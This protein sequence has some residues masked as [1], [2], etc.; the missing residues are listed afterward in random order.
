MSVFKLIH[1]KLFVSQGGIKLPLARFLKDE[2][3]KLNAASENKEEV[4]EVM[5]NEALSRGYVSESFLEKIKKREETFP[6]GLSL[7]HYGIAIPHTDAECIF[8]QFIGVITLQEPIVFQSMDDAS[9]EVYVK[10]ILMLGLN[11]PHNQ[12]AV[13]Q[14]I[15]QLVQ[16][17]E[18][19]E[20]LLAA[21][22]YEEVHKIFKELETI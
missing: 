17:E 19:Y 7:N 2:L 11:E 5:F 20:K 12:L 1:Y 14:Q 8:E 21:V 9:K 4:F 16:K 13:L 10:L 18:N 6:T 3:I 22:D 15:M